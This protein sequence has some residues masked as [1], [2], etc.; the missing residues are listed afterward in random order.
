MELSGK[1]QIFGI[2]GNPVEH[3]LSPLFQ[4]WFLEGCGI[5]AVYVPF[6]VEEDLVETALKGL[7]ASG[8]RGLNVTVPHK[9]TVLPLVEVDR[10]AGIIGA[11]NTLLR[12]DAGWRASNTDWRGFS[13]TL[14]AVAPEVRSGETVL[15][16]AGGTAKA[17]V[18]ALHDAGVQKIMI[19]NRS[20]ER[21]V[22]LKQH[23]EDHYTG[24]DVQL[25]DWEQES[26]SAATKAASTLINTTSIGLKGEAF[27]FELDGDGVA[28]DAVYRPDG[29]TA[30]CE[31][32]HSCGRY[33]V[34]GLPMLIAQGAASFA[35]WHGVG[36]PDRLTALRKVEKLLGRKEISLPGWEKAQ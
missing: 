10:D 31:A 35:L 21:A 6:R 33:S 28:I 30:F 19:C 14:Q 13:A 11:V 7:W 3:S 24:M 36:E 5:D 22:L 29:K 8:V 34:D 27:P 26:V 1:T 18:H 25:V 20:R 4:S 12:T 32:A 15:F 16:G 23:I 9:E 17:I 2:I